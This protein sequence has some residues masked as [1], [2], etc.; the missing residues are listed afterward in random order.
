M[1][2]PTRTLIANAAKLVAGSEPPQATMDLAALT[3]AQTDSPY[4]K[5]IDL[6]S[7][8]VVQPPTQFWFDDGEGG[9]VYDM[10]TKVVHP[11][12]EEE[13]RGND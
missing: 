8:S 12:R 11:I 2:I 6:L 10:K 1:A 9:A 7:E 5:V 3:M 13:P 4:K